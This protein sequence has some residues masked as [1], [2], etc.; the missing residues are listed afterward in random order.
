MSAIRYGCRFRPDERKR[1]GREGG[2]D[3]DDGVPVLRVNRESV[4]AA[5]ASGARAGTRSRTCARDETWER[6]GLAAV[7]YICGR[8]VLCENS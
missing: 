1:A 6:G 3:T 2:T 7:H 8:S 5:R 4:P